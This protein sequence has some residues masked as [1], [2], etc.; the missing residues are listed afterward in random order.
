MKKTCLIPIVLFGWLF[1]MQAQDNSSFS[2]MMPDTVAPGM[3]FEVVFSL[4][5]A[6][7]EGFEA[8]D[9]PGLQIVSG[10]NMS[11]SFSFMNGTSSQKMSYTYL[12][13]AENTGTL[14]IGQAKIYVD[15]QALKTEWKKIAV[16]EG[17]VMPRKKDPFDGFFNRREKDFFEWPEKQPK[18]DNYIDKK[19]SKKKTYRI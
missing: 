4:E 16:V 9:F 18:D 13:K 7:G 3:T 15:G 5:N 12:M 17:Y 19:K 1:V 8:P 14:S 6:K 2:V 11:S 10:P